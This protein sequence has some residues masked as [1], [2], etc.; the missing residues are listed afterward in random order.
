MEKQCIKLSSKLGGARVK[1]INNRGAEWLKIGKVYPVSRAD[2]RKLLINK[3]WWTCT[4]SDFEIETPAPKLNGY[5]RGPVTRIPRQS[6]LKVERGPD[7]DWHNQD[8]GSVYGYLLYETE[9]D[10]ARVV[11]MNEYG[12]QIRSRDYR[13]GAEGKY[14]LQFYTKVKQKNLENKPVY[15]DRPAQVEAE[16]TE[17]PQPDSFIKLRTAAIDKAMK[18]KPTLKYES[19][20]ISGYTMDELME[21][22]KRLHNAVE[23]GKKK[24]NNLWGIQENGDNQVM[25]EKSFAQ[26]EK[27]KSN[28]GFAAKEAFPLD[29]PS[30]FN[31]IPKD[32]E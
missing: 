7:W 32:L 6:N 27:K 3:I 9:P 5:W 26:K 13:I 22:G 18:P 12:D 2:K 29:Y 4:G 1:I 11:W 16:P 20:T 23:E 15:Y 25:P 19:S 31:D 21:A 17:L 30:F 8:E 10:W 14:D 24:K 28:P